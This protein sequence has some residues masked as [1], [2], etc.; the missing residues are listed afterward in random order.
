M[1][2]TRDHAAPARAADPF[3]LLDATAQAELVRRHEASPQEVRASNPR[4]R[5]VARVG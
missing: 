3:V 4:A 2:E 1:S 5:K